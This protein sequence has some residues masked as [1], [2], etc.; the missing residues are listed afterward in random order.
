MDAIDVALV[1]TDGKDKVTRG[2]GGSYPYPAALRDQLLAVIADT[3]RAKSDPLA[4][5]EAGVTQSHGDAIAQF[6]KENRIEPQTIDVI[7]LHGQ[8]V[9]HRPEQGITRQ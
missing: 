2:P 5:I 1:T 4:E 6:M 9:Y 7:G 8:T 3:S